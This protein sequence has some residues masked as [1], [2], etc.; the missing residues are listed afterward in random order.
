MAILTPDERYEVVNNGWQQLR[1]IGCN[2]ATAI[3]KAWEAA[4][5][6]GAYKGLPLSAEYTH[7]GGSVTAQF[8]DGGLAV[9]KDG[10]GA[11]S[12]SG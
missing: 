8:F 4:L 9:Y 11:A 6:A 5:L 10:M 3:Y 1:Q 2:P 7:A 12:W